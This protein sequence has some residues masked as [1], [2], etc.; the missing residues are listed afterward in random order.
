MTLR[1]TKGDENPLLRSFQSRLCTKSHSEPRPRGAL[2]LSLVFQPTGDPEAFACL[3]REAGLEARHTGSGGCLHNWNMQPLP[4]QELR[5]IDA[6]WRAANYLSVGQIYLYDNP[7]LS[8]P[9]KL[10]HIKPRR[11]ATGEPR[12]D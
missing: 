3:R 11:W 5:K 7:L 1:A 9:L 12:R 4:E 10:E 2:H 6:Y 8:E